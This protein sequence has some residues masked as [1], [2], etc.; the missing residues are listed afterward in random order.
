M[1][2]GDCEVKR[3]KVIWPFDGTDVTPSDIGTSGCSLL[4]EPQ[5]DLQRASI[6]GTLEVGNLHLCESIKAVTTRPGMEGL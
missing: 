6:S 1:Q 2:E 4:S 5:A 3:A